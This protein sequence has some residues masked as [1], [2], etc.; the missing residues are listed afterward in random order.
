AFST[1]YFQSTANAAT[2]AKYGRKAR[3]LF[4]EGG[5][6]MRLNAYSNYA[7]G[8][9]TLEEIYGT[10]VIGWQKE[11]DTE[12]VPKMD[13]FRFDVKDTERVESIVRGSRALAREGEAEM[14]KEMGDVTKDVN[15][16]VAKNTDGYT[17]DV[18][19]NDNP[20]FVNAYIPDTDPKSEYRS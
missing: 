9:E 16:K 3:Q 13:E 19:Q 12:V 1:Q 18:S 5:S 2:A 8:D 10:V 6:P 14:E 20:N 11:K 7:M 4:V 17:S 15:A